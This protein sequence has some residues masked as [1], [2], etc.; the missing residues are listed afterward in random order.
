MS[1]IATANPLFNEW[2]VLKTLTKIVCG[3]VF[4]IR[5]LDAQLPGHYQPGTI[6]GYFGH[7]NNCVNELKKLTSFKG[8]YIT[9]NPVNSALLARRENRLDYVAKDD[10]TKDQHIVRRRWLILDV[11]ADRPSGISSSSKEKQSARAMAGKIQNYLSGRGWPAPV[12]ADSGNGYHL[13]YHIDL[14]P[15]DGQLLEQVLGVLADRFAADGVKI[16]RTVHNPARIVRLYGTKAAKGDS[17]KERPHR[18]SKILLSE[19]GGWVTADQLRA[20]VDELRPKEPARV[21][22]APAFAGF[23][24]EVFLQ[25]HN[26]EVS[27]KTQE[28]SSAVRW[29][30]AKCPFNHDHVDGEAAV[31]Q[32]PDGKLGFKCFHNSCADKHW[33]DFRRHFEPVAE[34]QKAA[35]AVTALQEVSTVDAAPEEAEPLPQAPLYVPP[36]LDLLPVVLREY[37]VAASE[38]LSVDESFIF[39]P[40]LS[41]LGGTIGHSRTILLKHGFTQPP[42]IWTGIVG[43]SGARKSPAINL[44]CFAATER[45]REL[46]RRNNEALEIYKDEVAEWK[47]APGK[48]R[49]EKPEKPKF[50]AHLIDDLTIEVLGDLLETNPRGLFVRKDELAHWFSSFDQY[51]GGKGG[52]V[53]RWLSLHSAFYFAVDRR[54]ED[55]HYRLFDPRVSITGGIQPKVFKR[56]LTDDFL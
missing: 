42:V 16:D 30:L 35:P 33:K 39:L 31:F 56:A 44:G 47:A 55:R 32:R 12:F 28:P 17:T 2:E 5:A 15:D 43:V 25:R 7:P 23:D 18:L 1:T 24:V 53:T 50:L 3:D 29:D 8:V 52:D 51:R 48:R 11:D 20:L 46:T 4:E 13:L 19:H 41:S 6:S 45:E 40:M 22:S 49:V 9:L 34:H 21:Q 14:P 54:S 38:M 26:V 37:V 27:P 36:P 10:T